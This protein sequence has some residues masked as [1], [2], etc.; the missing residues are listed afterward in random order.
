ME[1]H[2][3]TH[4]PKRWKEYFW[5]FFMLFMA[6]FCG[7]LAEL[8]LEHYIEH[9]REKKYIE[10]VYKDL[11]KDTAF[12]SQH[13][14][15]L[16]GV[17]HLMDSMITQ[18][19]SDT[20]KNEPDQF[21]LMGLRARAGRYFEYYNTAFEQMKTSGNLRLIQNEQLLDSLVNYYYLLDKRVTIID[22]R[23]LDVLT[24]LTKAINTFFD[25]GYYTNN[26][27]F[28][29]GILYTRSFYTQN[30]RFPESTAQNKLLLKNLCH[31]R[32]G[33]VKSQVNF[34]MDLQKM[35][36]RLLQQIEKEYEI[37]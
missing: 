2:H 26:G 37:K 30:A 7:F 22:S 8:Q 28:D 20:Y 18:L 27:T 31:Q 25:A 34:L 35:S 36:T 3:H 16:S 13:K 17:Y 6:V 12:Y 1:V 32:K 29:D 5:E 23:G 14:K 10:R 9:Q 33:N 21:Y 11:K 15:Y 19:H 4:H 24:E